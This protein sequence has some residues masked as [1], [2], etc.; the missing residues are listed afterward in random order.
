MCCIET[1]CILLYADILLLNTDPSVILRTFGYERL[2]M[3]LIRLLE[4]DVCLVSLL[5]DDMI[6]DLVT[7]TPTFL[8]IS[9]LH[10]TEGILGLLRLIDPVQERGE[11]G[12]DPRVAR[13]G[14]A[15]A[16]GDDSYLRISVILSQN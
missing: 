15:L 8:A 5:T 13:L 9:G 2:T 4:A 16:P 1:G 7:Q 6:A 10:H 3:S 14:T 12:V 11:P